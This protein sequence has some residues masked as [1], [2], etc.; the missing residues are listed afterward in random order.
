MSQTAITHAFEHYLAEQQLGGQTVLL[1]EIVLA[2]LPGLDLTQPI[3]RA[4][5][6]PP[7][8]QIVH[9]QAV[10]QRGKVNANGVA[11]SIIMD[12]R[13]GN[14]T[15]NA[16]YLVNNASGLVAMVVHKEEEQKLK[17]Q[18]GQTGNSLVKSM[19]M[20]YQGAAQATD[21]Q[22]D[23]GTWQI[24]FSA[25]LLGL[26]RDIQLQALDHYGEAAFIQDGFAVRPGPGVDEFVV[27]PGLGYIAGL[28]AL[29]AGEQSLVVSQRPATLYAD[30]YHAGTLL[31][32]WHTQVQIRASATSL[33]DYVDGAGYPHYVTPLAQLAA[34]GTVTDLRGRGGLW[35]HE[36][37]PLAHTK[38]QV[39]LGNVENYPL[40]SQAEAEAGSSSARYMTPLR[41]KQAIDKLVGA[42]TQALINTKETPAGAQAK[43]NAH[44]NRT[45][46]P[47]GVTKAQ[48]GLGSVENY[49]LATQAEAEAGSSLVR[50]MS[51][52]RVKQAIDKL[53]GAA[54]QAAINARETPAGA[55]AKVNT[56]AN[57]TDNPHGVTKAQ[58]GL[59][60]VQNYAMATQAEAEAGSSSVRY[61]SPLRV[62]QAI[63]KLI[64][65]ATQA[66]I[67]AR[68]TP[69][70][71]QTKVNAHAN[72]TDNPH[73][74][75]KAQ[76]GLGS[77]QNYPV[78]T[79]AE[80]EAG[81]ASNRYMTPLRVKQ[82]IG[83]FAF[84]PTGEAFADGSGWAVIGSIS[85]PQGVKPLI[86]QWGDISITNGMKINFPISFPTKVTDIYLTD[87]DTGASTHELHTVRIDSPSLTGFIINAAAAGT[88]YWQAF[89]Y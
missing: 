17:T 5:G 81:T 68:E 25:R 30:V 35:W 26:D 15:F 63:D 45:D 33:A 56:H 29:L 2:H 22:V 36:N 48:V 13:I 61:M 43:V 77:V 66:A 8:A 65:T 59:G 34:N 71:A 12:T 67:N 44:A 86:K 49:P 84:T 83:K 27:A 20:E 89:G 57:R 75:T 4:A 87:Q 80:A 62:K 16:M 55:Q 88:T 41:V 37:R 7:A 19:L 58:V 38:A 51:P 24:D 10:D 85:T 69:T 78:A 60:S 82:A 21:T 54:T 32:D 40:A 50:Y 52:L 39:G 6:L 18:G 9:R 11:Y 47:H 42:A 64:G 76:V 73:S 23:A 1:D 14:F 46:N 3:D 53:I 70:G 72:R 79:Q 74:V 28:R 31:S